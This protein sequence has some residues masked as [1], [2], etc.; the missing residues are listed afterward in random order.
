MLLG[1]PTMSKTIGD[2]DLKSLVTRPCYA[3]GLP[4]VKD[5][6]IF[7]PKKSLRKV[8]EISVLNLSLADTPARICTDTSQKIPV[9]Y[10]IIISKYLRS[11]SHPADHCSLAAVADQFG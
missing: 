2:P 7:S 6:G 4:V 10:G 1:Y 9:W 8:I 3:E 11:G 5:P